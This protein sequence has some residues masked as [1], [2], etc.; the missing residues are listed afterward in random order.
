MEPLPQ[1]IILD[2][3]GTETPAWRA[4]EGPSLARQAGGRFFRAGV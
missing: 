2:V 3:V 4:S 1:C